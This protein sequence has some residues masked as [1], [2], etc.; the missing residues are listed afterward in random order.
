MLV[1]G[2]ESESGESVSDDNGDDLRIF[3]S[4]TVNATPAGATPCF[5]RSEGKF[6][7]SDTPLLP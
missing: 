7:R 2:T 1:V 4:V 5:S 3:C 6:G